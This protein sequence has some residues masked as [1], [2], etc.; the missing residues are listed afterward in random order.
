M[1]KIHSIGFR[2]IGLLLLFIFLIGVADAREYAYIGSS[3]TSNGTV[4]IFDLSTNSISSYVSPP[5]G[6]SNPG[7]F[8]INP[9]S[10]EVYIGYRYPSDRIGVLNPSTGVVYTNFPPGV[11]PTNMAV[12]PDGEKLYVSSS[13]S[14]TVYVY[15]TQNFTEKTH[16]S[17]S[18]NA[19]FGMEFSP[20]GTRLYISS[21]GQSRV[22]VV[23][24]TSDSYITGVRSVP[25]YT[26]VYDVC[27]DPTSS[28]GYFVS[29]DG[30]AY[31]VFN[32]STNTLTDTIYVS[33][34]PRMVKI[35]SDGSTLYIGTN[36]AVL[37]YDTST[38]SYVTSISLTGSAYGGFEF[39][40]DESKLYAILYSTGDYNTIAVIDTATYSVS[41]YTDS[42]VSN[43]YSGYG[44]F[45]G[46]GDVSG[47][48]AAN[49]TSGYVP[50]DVQ[51]T[52]YSTGSPSSWS[53]DFGDGGTS[54]S[55]NPVHT[56]SSTGVYDV[57]LNV[58]NSEGYDVFTRYSYITASGT[59]VSCDFIANTTYVSLGDPIL[60]T[61]TSTGDD[62]DTWTWDIN[63]DGVTDGTT[64]SMTVYYG[65]VGTYTVTHSA[66]SSVTGASDSET[67]T[68]YITV[69]NG[70]GCIGCNFTANITSGQ[71]PLTV[72][73]SD[74]STGTP[75]AWYW[76]FGDGYTSTEQNPVH[77]YSST[78]SYDVEFTATN[79]TA[80]ISKTKAKT[81][82]ITVSGPS[83]PTCDFT[84]NVTYG[85]APLTVLFTDTSTGNPTSWTW[86]IDGVYQ[87]DT[88][89]MTVTFNTAG[90]YSITHTATNAEGTGTET[91]TDYIQVYSANY[92]GIYGYIY[93]ADT[94]GPISS[95]NCQL[96]NS[97]ATATILSDSDG[98]YYFWPVYNGVYDL[99]ISKSG[100]TT[101]TLP[102]TIINGTTLRQDIYLTQSGDIVQDENITNYSS[103]WLTFELTT[104]A[105]TKKITLDYEVIQGNTNYANCTIYDD[106]GP[107]YSSNVSTQSGTFSY[108]GSAGNNYLVSF[109]IM[110][111]EGNRYSGA[112][113]VLFYRGFPS[114]NPIFPPDMPRGIINGIL[115]F[116]A[117]V[118]MMMFGKAYIEIGMILGT[119]VLAS[120]YIWGFLNFPESVKIPV[121]IFLSALVAGGELI[122]KKKV[123]G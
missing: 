81:D 40:E 65:T 75:D 11:E 97:S 90:T 58:S 82:Y 27:I 84:A 4:S 54:T 79:T 116:A 102:N 34:N 14:S 6:Y 72:Q 83:A 16:F 8:A 100:Y 106:S 15:W 50:F 98:Y 23:N 48:F 66:S 74:L 49:V 86:E 13:G 47:N 64:E 91:K 70:V 93:D 109:D 59:S 111:D 3:S 56:Y 7:A 67:K 52:D 99:T 88:Q 80:G 24:A 28:T 35:S 5:G 10:Y 51:F 18:Y 36:S 112:Y 19:G 122:A 113:P 104:D 46:S 57:T 53:W 60:F 63:G 119:A 85:N 103:D 2:K 92:G 62:I 12:S 73:F 96:S 55:Q 123:L 77:T 76:D 21:V 107:V 20:D 43:A 87:A 17:I 25:T 121:I 22:L 71:A 89:D 30:H 29:S 117:I 39:N 95:V 101:G 37:V 33:G 118:C 120:S 115:V 9:V 44:D 78:G 69:I 94:D 38:N 45:I 114:S 61:D 32:T 42:F 1:K 108:T 41:Y 110:N 105:D 26:G 31:Y 68:N